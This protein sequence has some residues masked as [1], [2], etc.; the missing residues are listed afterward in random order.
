MWKMERYALPLPTPMRKPGLFQ[1][2]K[3][4]DY[5]L[6][7][8]EAKR[9]AITPELT[10]VR[11]PE[12]VGIIRKRRVRALASSLRAHTGTHAKFDARRDHNLRRGRDPQRNGSRYV[13]D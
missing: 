1:D 3:R 8:G 7:H 2:G 6:C 5:Y 10:E 9:R 4:P 11:A 12:P 13:C